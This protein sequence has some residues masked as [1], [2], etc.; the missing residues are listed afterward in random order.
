MY[1]LSTI[2]NPAIA[3]HDGEESNVRLMFSTPKSEENL[4]SSTVFDNE[5]SKQSVRGE[6]AP[7]E[8]PAIR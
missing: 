4:Q 8:I 3:T 2:A 7:R 6:S 5:G 1:A